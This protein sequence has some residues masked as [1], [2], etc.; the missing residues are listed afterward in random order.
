MKPLSEKSPKEIYLYE[1]SRK[2][3]NKSAVNES[4]DAPD[5]RLISLRDFKR[6]N[7]FPSYETHKGMLISPEIYDRDL[8]FVVF[9]SHCWLWNELESD[10]YDGIPHPDNQS[11]SKFKLCIDG[12]KITCSVWND[13]LVILEKVEYI[14]KTIKI[15]CPT[16]TTNI[17]TSWPNLSYYDVRNEVTGENSYRS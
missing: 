10:G 11:N 16:I 7:S 9:I 14:K 2:Q 12:V 3:S 13:E 17:S 1:V 6:S 15:I 4:L 8:S 5:I